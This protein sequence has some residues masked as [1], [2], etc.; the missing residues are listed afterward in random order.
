M[1]NAINPPVGSPAK[2]YPARLAGTFATVADALR[3][4][5]F[6]T[7]DAEMLVRKAAING[8][9]AVFAHVGEGKGLATTRLPDGAV[10]LWQACVGLLCDTPA[11]AQRYAQEMD[12][13][14]GEMRG[15]TWAVFEWRKQVC[16]ASH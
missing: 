8:S 5:G 11:E 7:H 6:S 10:G 4:E 2:F 13:R 9:D 16:T 14:L 3:S 1:K 12:A 15:S